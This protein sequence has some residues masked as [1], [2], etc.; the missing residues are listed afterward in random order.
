MIELIA[1]D[2]D[3]TLWHNELYYSQAQEILKQILKA[4][5]PKPD[6]E[7]QLFQV[8]S[9]NMVHFGYGIKAFGLSMVE[10]ACQLSSG[11]ITG[12]DIARIIALVHDMLSKPV[13]LLDQVVP[14]LEALS[15]RYPLMLLTKGDLL[16]QERKVKRSG[17]QKY[18]QYVEI[19]SDKTP[20]TYERI[21]K[22]IPVKPGNFLMIGNSMRSDVLPVVALGGKAVYIPYHL[23]WAHE[24]VEATNGEQFYELEHLGQLP[25]LIEQIENQI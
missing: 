10:T 25:A 14:A 11:R 17:V 21:L 1:F 18:F 16:E 12:E 4:Y 2:A 3:D 7:D 8:E 22:R 13:E 20:E 19:I 9:R 23:T 6:L 24:V 15:A 5:Y